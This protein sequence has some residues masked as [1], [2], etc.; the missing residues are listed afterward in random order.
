MARTHRHSEGGYAMV[1]ALVALAVMSVLAIAAISQAE[2]ALRMSRQALRTEQALYMANGGVEA[3]LAMRR[4]GAHIDVDPNHYTYTMELEPGL[5]GAYD[6]VVSTPDSTPGVMMIQSVGTVTGFG[7]T[8]TRRVDATIPF[9]DPPDEPPPPPQAPLGNSS[10]YLDKGADICGDLYANGDLFLDKN[11]TVWKQTQAQNKK[12][13]CDTIL[14]EGKAVA[15]GTLTKDDKTVIQGGWCDGAHYAPGTPCNGT[16]PVVRSVPFPDF[17][18][19]KKKAL[20]WWVKWEDRGFCSDKP[21]GSCFVLFGGTLYDLGVW[22]YSNDVIYIDGD[23]EVIGPL[24]IS[25]NVTF[26]VTGKVTMKSDVRCL[27]GTTCNISF[28]SAGPI[29]LGNHNDIQANLITNSS[30]MGNHVTVRG[31]ITASTFDLKNGFTLYPGT[32]YPV[33]LPDNPPPGPNP[34]PPAAGFSKWSQ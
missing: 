23:M 11:V 19:L 3:I 9:Q 4:A 13:P 20:R 8:F 10:L 28:V 6:V 1:T 16:K 30:L 27:S 25:G 31:L 26:A 17:A 14:G 7:E 21:F 12:S 32:R 2:S 34:P 29:D 5:Q 22:F 15:T 33:G 24:D 18:E